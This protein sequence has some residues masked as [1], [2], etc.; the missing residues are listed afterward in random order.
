MKSKNSFKIIFAG[1]PPFAATILQAL[2][3]SQHSIQAVY[4]QPDRPAGR[5]RKLTA[6]AVK[7]T[8]LAKELPLYQPL[9]LRAEEEQKKLAAL[10][11]D[12][13]IVVAYG[14]I[15]PK[16]IL[17]IPPLG[18][19]NIHASLLPNWRGAAPIQRAILAGDNKTGITVM[20]MDEGLD[21][22]AMLYKVECPIAK[23]DTSQSLH[24]RL[25]DLGAKAILYTLD[26]LSDLKSVPQN[27]SAATYAHK[28]KKEEALL[29][30]NL[31]AEEIVRK[32]R[33][34]NP[35]P[36]AFFNNIRVWEAEVI[37]KDCGD[38]KPGT[39]VQSSSDGIDVATGNNFLRLLTIQLA[40]G[41]ILPVKAILN[42]KPEQLKVGN[43]F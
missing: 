41:K 14:L 34:F 13:M 18:C 11:A 28:I 35:W 39:I 21:T 2:I 6:S 31:S 29:D 30:W 24:D 1:T 36:V 42:A 23:T 10:N 33:A 40:G 43:I 25:A 17:S 3:Q 8:A 4:T 16:S 32:V 20:Q 22:G 15:L 7:E 37:E 12:I 27:N 9:T 19:I 5:G 38:F 26:H